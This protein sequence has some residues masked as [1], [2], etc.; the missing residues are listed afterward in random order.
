MTND[1][2]WEAWKQAARYALPTA[3]LMF[4]A[5]MVG[6]FTRVGMAAGF[7]IAG[8]IWVVGSIVGVLRFRA[9]HRKLTVSSG[10]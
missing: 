7:A 6:V 2:L 5:M 4:A 3:A 10:T 1:Q 9:W 8:A